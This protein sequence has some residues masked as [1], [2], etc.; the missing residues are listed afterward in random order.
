MT[1]ME[2]KKEKTNLES[3][4]IFLTCTNCGHKEEVDFTTGLGL[5]LLLSEAE[6]EKT[7]RG[8]DYEF[9][10]HGC[11]DCKEDL[12]KLSNVRILTEE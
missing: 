4:Q 11:L 1:E 7:K 6:I 8:K 5:V 10:A 9:L 12:S 2:K 3:K